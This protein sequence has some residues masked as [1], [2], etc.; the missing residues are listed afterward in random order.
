[1]SIMHTADLESTQSQEGGEL[2][3]PIFATFLAN[4]LRPCSHRLFLSCKEAKNPTKL[5]AK[6]M[7]TGFLRGKYL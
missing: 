3:C 7:D 1:M 5:N 6:I 4:S 2:W